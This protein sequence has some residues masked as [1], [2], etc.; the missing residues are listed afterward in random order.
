VAALSAVP[1]FD[2]FSKRHLRRLA[3]EADVVE[4]DP[5][6]AIVEEGQAGEALFVILGGSARVVRNGKKVATLIPGDFFGE[7]SALDGGPRTASVVPE[8]PVEVLRVFRHTLRMMVTEEPGLVLGLL[9]GL[10]RRMRQIRP[11]TP[12]A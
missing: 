7:L 9:E 10:A 11:G 12:V 3:A 8:T 5:G 4:F 6:R 2:G 1:L